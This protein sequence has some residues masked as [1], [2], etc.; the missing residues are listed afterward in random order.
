MPIPRFASAVF[1]RLPRFVQ[2]PARR[3]LSKRAIAR[4]RAEVRPFLAK[5]DV[6]INGFDGKCVVEIGGDLDALT[7]RLVGELYAPTELIGFNPAIESCQ[8]AENIHVVQAGAQD[9]G[10]KDES[11]DA[12]F[13][14]SAFEHIRDLDAVLEEMYRVLVP[15]GLLYSDFGPVWSSP[16]G[17]HLW[18][19]DGAL[20]LNYHNVLLPPWCHLLSTRGDVRQIL[21]PRY[22]RDLAA[23]MVDFVFDSDQQ[24][25][26]F[27]EDYERI[28]KASQFEAVFLKGYDHP[29]LATKYPASQ[30]P[31]VL[32]ALQERFP[33]RQGFLYDGITM[34]LRRP[35]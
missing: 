28:V 20:L 6:A 25:Q 21:E 8:I 22:G 18:V 1:E 27:F 16:Y 7:L 29:E 23:H 33:E 4:Y 26:L 15:G 9:S 32:D 17:H 11:V 34:L 14:S 5:V 30:S 31:D 13:S 2:A 19:E 12:V 3:T 35:H 10:L 24:N